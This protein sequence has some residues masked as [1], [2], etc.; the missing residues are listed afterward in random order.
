MI[1][2][3]FRLGLP[4]TLFRHEPEFYEKAPQTNDGFA[5]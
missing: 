4:S 3:N 2:H 1:I 5:I